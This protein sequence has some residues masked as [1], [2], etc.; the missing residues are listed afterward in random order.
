MGTDGG[1]SVRG[2]GEI[3]SDAHAGSEAE[4][5]APGLGE[6]VARAGADPSGSG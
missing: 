4:G 6:R 1:L 3:R 2:V 5:T